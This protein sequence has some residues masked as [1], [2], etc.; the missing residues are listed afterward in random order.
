MYVSV[1]TCIYFKFAAA[2][3][4]AVGDNW[5][6]Y[7][8]YSSS[9]SKHWQSRY[10]FNRPQQDSVEAATIVGTS[11]DVI[12][13]S[14]RPTRPVTGPVTGLVMTRRRAHGQEEGR[15]GGME[16]A[17]ILTWLT[18]Q[19]LRLLADSEGMGTWQTPG[20]GTWQTPRQVWQ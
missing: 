8:S 6:G 15:E 12:A 20:M 11:I 3:D 14:V 4:E 2:S 19:S 1:S 10:C 9:S 17:V 5:D 18:T 16:G 13:L 7:R